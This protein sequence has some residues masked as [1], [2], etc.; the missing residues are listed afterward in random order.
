ML[1]VG[2]AGVGGISG[3]HIPAW[4]AMEDTC[5]TALCD[6]RPERLESHPDKHCYTDF[7]EMLEKE[8]LDILDICLPT[9]LHADYAVRAL[10]R[11]IHVICE[12]PISLK[13]CDI[14]RIYQTAREHHA[15]FMVAQVLRFWP[16]YELVKELYD[17]K[18]YGRLLSASMSR[19]G[20]TPKW[21]LD[22]WMLDEN[23]SGL[24]PFD[25][26][27]HELDFITYAFGSPQKQQV[28]RVK[29]PDQD[30]LDITYEYPDFF[31]STEAAWYAVPYSFRASY[32]FQFEKALIV[33]EKE[34]CAIYEN[35]GAVIDLTN[36]GLGETGQINL[37]KSNA[38][39]NEI[40]YFTD[41]VLKGESPDKIKPRELKAVLRILNN[42]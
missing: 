18:K 34:Q 25:L 5:L 35:S 30:Y 15:H 31:I 21:S 24:V 19:L 37:P 10:N 13:E 7:E 22:N 11:G 36:S 4:N 39:A 16:E 14:D 9:Y 42:I 33:Y 41:C 12:K 23:R 6:I 3:A 2:L 38:Y 26:H 32:R 27:I 40:R 28:H 8:D 29:Q 17:S 20:E 1:K